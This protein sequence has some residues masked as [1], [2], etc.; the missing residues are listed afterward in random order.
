M[1]NLNDMDYY[2]QFPTAIPSKGYVVYAL[3]TRAPLTFG[4]EDQ[5]PFDLHVCRWRSS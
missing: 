5:D 2:W 4:P 3:R 1:P